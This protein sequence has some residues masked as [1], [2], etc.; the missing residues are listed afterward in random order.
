MGAAS[1]RRNREAVARQAARQPTANPVP[2]NIP[3][4]EHVRAVQELTQKYEIKLSDLGNSDKMVA[5]LDAA[6]AEGKRLADEGDRLASELEALKDDATITV[7]LN[8]VEEVVES[9]DQAAALLNTV[10]AENER[11]TGEVTALQALLDESTEE[12]EKPKGK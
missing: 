5:S 6:V 10:G 1:L 4:A 2:A 8:G 9:L 7:Q 3:Y 11:L 12:T